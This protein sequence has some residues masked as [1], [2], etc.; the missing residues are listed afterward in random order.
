MKK[1]ACVALLLAALAGPVAADSY[2]ALNAGIQLY[3]G[4]DWK[5]A[6]PLFDQALAGKDL[7]PGLQ[8]V[9]HY[10]RGAAKAASGDIE[11]ALA[12]FNAALTLRPN[13][14]VTLFGRIEIYMKQD[15]YS[16]AM[17]DITALVASFPGSS[18]ALH[19]R[20]LI[21]AEKGDAEALAKDIP[22]LRASGGG[23]GLRMYLG[24]LEWQTGQIA[25]AEKDIAAAQSAAPASLYPWLWL[26]MVEIRLGK[27]VPKAP[28][29]TAGKW[30]APVVQFYRGEVN[31]E[32]VM[33]AA[34]N[35]NDQGHVCEASFYIGEWRLQH[36]DPAGARGFLQKAAD[37]CPSGFIE[38]ASARSDLK[39]LP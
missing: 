35:D 38:T 37:T 34:Q 6:I 12:D 13:D 28:D 24:T 16:E 26:A 29:N 10:D 36:H 9:A 22:D 7:V 31:E 11:G 3:N 19:M 17:A 27:P 14:P 15:K 18:A 30:P 25:E 2:D 33:A 5:A 32:A 4:R 8:Y 21:N 23:A 20:A 1:H 39:K